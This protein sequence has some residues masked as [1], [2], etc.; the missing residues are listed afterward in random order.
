MSE[1]VAQPCH[2]ANEPS[3]PMTDEALA[4]LARAALSDVPDPE[5]GIDIVS[6]GL[7]YGVEADGSRGAVK[8]VFT[9]TSPACPAGD[10]LVAGIERR[11]GREAAIRHVELDLTFEPAWGP[12]RISAETRA[13]LG[14][15]E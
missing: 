5:T 9:F 13:M 15:E 2:E 10:A 3:E 12:E 1:A 14:I 4:A 6:L 7:V 11:L 8:V